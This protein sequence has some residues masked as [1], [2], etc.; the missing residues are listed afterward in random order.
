MPGE[1]G[2]DWLKR[3]RIEELKTPVIIVSESDPK[4][5]E[6]IFGALDNGA[7]DYVVKSELFTNNDYLKSLCLEVTNKKDLTVFNLNAVKNKSLKHADLIVIGA[8]TGGPAALSHMLVD[9]PSEF[10]PVVIVQHISYEFSKALH[11]RLCSSSKLAMGN[12]NP[13][14]PL[15]KNTLYMAHGEYHLK[16]NQTSNSFLLLEDNGQKVSGHI[17]SVD[18]LFESVAS[19]RCNVIAIL[20]T[21]M[22]EDGAR[23]LLSIHQR[24]NSFTMAQDENS[25]VVFGMPKKAL[26]LGAVDFVGSIEQL[27]ARILQLLGHEAKGIK[28]VA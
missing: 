25:S 28:N 22:G 19:T 7:Q 17:P 4:E 23:G 10:P 11:E 15:Q 24:S 21:G 12:L 6:K 20:L 26:E 1:S 13:Y 14:L 9:L 18:V 5:A 27:R 2:S 3:K 8:S 16:V